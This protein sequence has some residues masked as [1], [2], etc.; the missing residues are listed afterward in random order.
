MWVTGAS[1]EAGVR[2]LRHR[3]ELRLGPARAW[4]STE[5]LA[6]IETWVGDETPGCPRCATPVEPG[7]SF[8]RCPACEV[9]HHQMDDRD[10]WTHADRCALCSQPS[11]LDAGFRFRPEDF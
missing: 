1:L 3:D 9:V 2:A 11:A 6:G 10:C 7:H 8:V 4:F 5:R